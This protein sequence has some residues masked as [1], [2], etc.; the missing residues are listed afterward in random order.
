MRTRPDPTD[1]H[2]E[3]RCA[4]L[5][6][7]PDWLMR[8]HGRTPNPRETHRRAARGVPRQRAPIRRVMSA[9]TGTTGHQPDPG[10]RHEPNYLLQLSVDG[11]AGSVDAIGVPL[12]TERIWS[13]RVGGGQSDRDDRDP[14]L[15]RGIACCVELQEV[16]PRPGR[17]TVA[18]GLRAVSDGFGWAR[19]R[20]RCVR[21]V[22]ASIRLWPSTRQPRRERRA[23]TPLLR[24]GVRRLPC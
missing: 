7:W 9:T 13:L 18:L 20:R 6:A 2:R 3:Q 4:A 11:H 19:A 21:C 14:V 24:F 5:S 17:T 8:K 15:N 10:G 16:S 22:V 1:D 12:V 23:G